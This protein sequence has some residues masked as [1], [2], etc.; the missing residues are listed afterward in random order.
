MLLDERPGIGIADCPIFSEDHRGQ[1]PAVFH[2]AQAAADCD[3]NLTAQAAG[4]VTVN[5]FDALTPGLPG[6]LQLSQ[7]PLSRLLDGGH[8]FFEVDDLKHFSLEIG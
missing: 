7:H 2:L 1:F 4:S 3:P 6:E 5:E 8:A